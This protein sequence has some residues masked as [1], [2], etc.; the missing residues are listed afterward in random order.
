MSRNGRR[1][2]TSW[3]GALALGSAS[4][5]AVAPGVLALA[6]TALLPAADTVGVDTVS[7]GPGTGVRW[8]AAGIAVGA[9]A[10]PIF[11]V[12]WARRRWDGYVLLGLGLSLLV[13]AVGLGMVGIL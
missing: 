13:G 11:T 12:R 10:L 7:R 3:P 9:L 5:L 6:G 8:L 1:W 4:L 2:W